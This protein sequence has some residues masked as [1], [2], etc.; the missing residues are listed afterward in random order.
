MPSPASC[1]LL[2]ALLLAVLAVG[3]SN[4]GLFQ[5]FAAASQALGTVSVAAG[6]VVGAGANASILFTVKAVRVLNMAA[7]SVDE[8]AHGVD[9]LNVTLKRTHCKVAA[10]SQADLARWI[11]TR[12]S[13][14]VEARD[15]FVEQAW[16]VSYGIPALDTTQ[17]LIV[18]NGSFVSLRCRVRVRR[19]LSAALA[20]TVTLADFEPMWANPLWDLFGFDALSESSQIIS[21]LQDSIKSMGEVAAS[22]LDISDAALLRE[23]DLALLFFSWFLTVREFGMVLLVVLII[24]AAV[25]F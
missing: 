16:A 22:L 13:L 25:Y 7:D 14:P 2:F 9:L 15:W 24:S 8:F 4:A 6:N 1:K 11:G 20:L 23:F 19:D 3:Y 17:E 10:R 18:V 21:L 12:S 5:G